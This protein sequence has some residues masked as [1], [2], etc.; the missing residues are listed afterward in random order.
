MKISCSSHGEGL[1]AI[2]C[3]HHLKVQTRAVGFVENSDDPNDLQAWCDECEDL[4]VR[5]GDK[6]KK[7]LKVNDAAMVC[8]ACYA[9]LKSRHSRQPQAPPVGYNCSECGNVHDE[10][11]QYFMW[12]LP[13]GA[14]G[15]TLDVVEDG[16]S[17]CRS[18]NQAFVLCEIEVPVIGAAETVL[19]FICWVEVDSSDYERL[20]AFRENEDAHPDYTSLVAGTLANPVIGVPG[21]FGTRVKFAIVKDDPTP[22][23]KWVAPGTKLAALVRK[24]ASRRFWHDVAAEL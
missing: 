20:R 4:F 12:K 6:T 10:L 19:G 3:R 2:V 11:P 23:V 21:S 8:V 5:E 17:M 13:E 9:Q 18:A 14:D 7:F 16:Q 1:A 22:Y 15:L 24:G